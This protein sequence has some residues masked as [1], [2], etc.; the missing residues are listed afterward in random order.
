MSSIPLKR[1]PAPDRDAVIARAACYDGDTCFVGWRHSTILQEHFMPAKRTMTQE[2]QGFV[3][4][5]GYFWNRYQSARI[6]SRARQTAKLHNLLISEE[7]WDND[8]VPLNALYV[9]DHGDPQVVAQRRKA[10]LLAT[11]QQITSGEN[12]KDKEEPC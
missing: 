3:D 8:G 7:L 1:K 4:Q 9:R 2:C 6:A 12:P 10:A 5:H 11:E